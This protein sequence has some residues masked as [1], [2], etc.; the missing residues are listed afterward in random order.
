MAAKDQL[1][2]HSR[3]TDFGFTGQRDYSYIQLID[4]NARFYSP[5]LGRFIQPDTV[6]SYPNNPQSLN[7]FSYVL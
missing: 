1:S 5:T 2:E 6:T 3:F 7:R 4:F